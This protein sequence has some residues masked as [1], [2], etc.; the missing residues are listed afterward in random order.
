MFWLDT[1]RMAAIRIGQNV[2]EDEK[3]SPSIS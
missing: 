2:I 3:L 1:D